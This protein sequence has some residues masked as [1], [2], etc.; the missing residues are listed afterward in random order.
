M[1]AAPH[2]IARQLVEMRR[3]MLQ[4]G[5]NQ[6][7]RQQQRPKIDEEPSHAFNLARCDKLSTGTVDCS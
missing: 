5:H 6:S 4:R 1:A 3:E 7:D 2:D